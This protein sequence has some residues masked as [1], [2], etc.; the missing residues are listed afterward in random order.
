[1]PLQCCTLSALVRILLLKIRQLDIVCD[2]TWGLELVLIRVG[3]GEGVDRFRGWQEVEQ[4]KQ[5]DRQQLDKHSDIG[6]TR[7][8]LRP[9]T[10]VC[11]AS[12]EMKRSKLPKLP[13]IGR[14][15]P[16]KEEVS[17]NLIWVNVILIEPIV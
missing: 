12:S 13:G 7:T 4:Q 3:A 8:L 9:M 2:S 6:T 1:M 5:Q 10:M 11:S 16:T 14:S 15:H 17:E